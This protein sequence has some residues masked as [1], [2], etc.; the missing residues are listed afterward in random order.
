VD[1][2]TFDCFPDV[3]GIETVVRVRIARA[4]A[5]ELHPLLNDPLHD[6]HKICGTLVKNY[7]SELLANKRLTLCPSLKPDKWPMRVDCEVILPDGRNL[8]D[9]LLDKGFATTMGLRGHRDPWTAAQF[10]HIQRELQ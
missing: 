3:D 9:I 4:N 1:G 7:V 8:S 2:D 10:D 6:K 5:P